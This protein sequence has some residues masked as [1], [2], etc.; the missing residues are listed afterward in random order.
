MISIID[1]GIGNLGSIFNMLKYVNIPAIITSDPKVI[2]SS[3]HLILPG[4]GSFDN[5]MKKLM[6]MDLLTVLHHEV[7]NNQ[8]P[9]L[10]ICLGA[11]LMLESSEEGILPGLCWINGKCVKF[12]S[13]NGVKIPHMGW[14]TL[15][16]INDRELFNE[17]PLYPPRFYF[18][19][20]FHFTVKSESEISATT[21]Y[22][23]EFISAFRKDNV[24]GL[25][26]H[27]EKSHKFGMQVLSN[28]YKLK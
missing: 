5:G 24:I 3:S 26:F 19:H 12:N 23:N 27:P 17:M 16:K 21:I 13:S 20:S 8:K 6:E 2:S 9:V 1:Y 4:V 18:V 15:H 28:F 10:G 11:Q 7:K 25:Q 22:G 14:N